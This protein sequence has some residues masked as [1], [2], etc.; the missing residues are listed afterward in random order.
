MPNKSRNADAPPL[1]RHPRR[2]LRRFLHAH[3]KGADPRPAHPANKSWLAARPDFPLQTWLHPLRITLPIPGIGDVTLEAESNPFELLRLGT[4]ARSCLAPGACNSP[5]AVAVLLDIN[6]RAIYA[7]HANGR[8]LAR[9][10]VAISDDGHLI[11][12]RVYPENTAPALEDF[13]QLFVEDWALQMRLPIAG[14]GHHTVAALTLPT[15]YDDG[16]WARINP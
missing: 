15:W 16:L 1:P 2:P 7:R 12:Y 3:S 9:Q 10:I 14:A 6:K 5:N 11:P 8:F 4:Y 13:F